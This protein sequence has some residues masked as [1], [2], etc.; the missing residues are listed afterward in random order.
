MTVLAATIVWCTLIHTVWVLPL[1]SWTAVAVEGNNNGGVAGGT[2]DLHAVGAITQKNFNKTMIMFTDISDVND[3]CTHPDD[4]NDTACKAAHIKIDKFDADT[5]RATLESMD[6]KRYVHRI[7]I[8]Y[9]NLTETQTGIDKVIDEF[10]TPR[11]WWILVSQGR[12]TRLAGSIMRHI[13]LVRQ[14]H[15]ENELRFIA[16]LQ[17]P[18]QDVCENSPLLMGHMVDAGWGSQ[19]LLYGMYAGNDIYKVFNI[20]DSSFNRPN[21]STYYVNHGDCPD[22][23]NKR[24]CMFLPMTNCSVPN[25]VKNRIA[26][27]ERVRMWEG[28]LQ[29]YSNASSGGVLLPAGKGEGF[30]GKAP[31]LPYHAQLLETFVVSRNGNWP[32]AILS[33]HVYGADGRRIDVEGHNKFGNPM[34][35]AFLLPQAFLFRANARYRRMLFEL[36]AEY[37]AK[38]KFPISASFDCVAVHIR[39]GDRVINNEGDAEQEQEVSRGEFCHRYRMKSDGKCYRPTSDGQATEVISGNICRDRLNDLGCFSHRAFGSL[40]L[41]DYLNAAKALAPYTRTAV[42]LTDDQH[43]LRQQIGGLNDTMSKE[44]T[45][46]SVPARFERREVGHETDS[47]L[48]YL[49]SFFFAR[50]CHSFVGH[51]WSGFAKMIYQAMCFQHGTVAGHCP[52]VY[53][54]GRIYASNGEDINS[55]YICDS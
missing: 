47:G 18:P 46:H 31:F 3:S 22:L 36:V 43:W 52:G 49:M 27:G 13:F 38:H 40:S 33:P 54:V 28:D 24:L 32:D 30:V 1:F 2:G 55:C 29:Y 41:V 37:K 19:A 23:V 53:D 16:S 51:F 39:R 42:V 8:D 7:H 4:S 15:W 34:V 45:V 44:W 17:F 6:S 9:R 5:T 48:D 12:H 21:E 35:S 50:Q 25:A 26:H 11:P 10:I 14:A 20:W